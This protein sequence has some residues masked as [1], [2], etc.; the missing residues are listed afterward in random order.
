MPARLENDLAVQQA[1][2]DLQRRLMEALAERDE[3]EAQK[4]A[5]SEVLEVI[6]SSSGN[7]A[8]VFKAMLEKAMTL[9]GAS[10]GELRTYDG[11]RFLLAATH[12]VPAA[13]TEYYSRHELHPVSTGHRQ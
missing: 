8:P 3:A 4:A 9:C 10:F 7:L 12:G 13:Y 6:N 5:M 11:E 2:A 1:N